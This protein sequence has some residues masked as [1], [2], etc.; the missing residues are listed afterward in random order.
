MSSA[1]ISIIIPVYNTPEKYLRNCLKS[2]LSQSVQN[3]EVIAIDDGSTDNSGKIC[4]DISANDNRLKIIHTKNKG[5]SNARNVGIENSNAPYIIFLDA[6]DHLEA[7]VCEKCLNILAKNSKD[8]VFYKPVSKIKDTGLYES[9]DKSFIRTMQIDIICHTDN[10]AGFVYGSPWGKVF[11]RDFLNKHSLRFTLGV[12]RSQDRLFMLYC[13][14]MANSIGL[15]H[16][17]GYNYVRN[18]ESICNKYN[19]NIVS[20]L[21]NATNHI[22]NFVITFHSNDLD[23]QDAMYQ[24]RIKFA[25][26]EMQL[27]YLNPQRALSVVEAGKQLKS[28]FG[29]EPLKSSLAHINLDYCHGKAKVVYMLIVRKLYCL[30]ALSYKLMNYGVKLRDKLSNK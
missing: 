26:T 14:E 11:R 27:Y 16:Y 3:I 4:D 19:E 2:A 15:Y 29:E 13:L 6:D 7:D 18:T 17:S 24:L 21:D 25:F 1:E 10:Y 9:K 20:I 30:A 8:I 5:V 12:K 22:S 28:I 23:F